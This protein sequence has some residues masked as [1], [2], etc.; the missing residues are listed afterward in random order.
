VDFEYAYTRL[1]RYLERSRG[2][3]KCYNAVLLIQLRNG[4]R[5]SEAVRAFKEFLRTKR[6][7]LTVRLSKSRRERVRVVVIPREL[8]STDLSECYEL[9]D[10][11]DKAL[12][13]RVVNY[14]RRRHKF[15]T[16]SL[17]YAFITYLLK[18]GVNPA[19]VSKITGHT[20]LDYILTYTQEKLAG[21]ILKHLL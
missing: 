20:K 15:N 11:S 18:I 3:S 8:A 7:E 5:V 16:H 21:E 12:R 14:C 19:L 1:L 10:V 17:R 6:L 2:L 4:S 13:D 9:L